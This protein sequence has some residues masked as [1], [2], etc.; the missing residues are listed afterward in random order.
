MR[1]VWFSTL[2]HICLCGFQ[3]LINKTLNV[4]GFYEVFYF[5]KPYARSEVHL[6]EI[7]ETVCDSFKNYAE[8]T[9]IAGKKSIARTEARDGKTLSLS[10]IKISA[11]TGKQLKH[12]VISYCILPLREPNG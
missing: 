10:N 3:L 12:R 9:N 4:K 8:T 6:L 7:F 2:N 5:Q 1:F 11:E